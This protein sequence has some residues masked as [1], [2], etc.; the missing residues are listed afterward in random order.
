MA[1][2]PKKYRRMALRR[3]AGLREL[4]KEKPRLA[5]SES[6]LVAHACFSCRKSFKVHPRPNF[7]AKC[8][9]CG[10][11][12]YAMGRSFKAPPRGDK[13]QWLKVQSLYAYG[14]RFFSYRSCP[15]APKLPERLREVEEFVTANPQHPFRVA[16][17]NQALQPTSPLTRR[18]V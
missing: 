4:P 3:A 17:P 13:E 15:S 6:Y 10:G 2:N 11:A 14:F 7:M 5:P 9:D 16:A 8:P 12:M 1:V 18:R